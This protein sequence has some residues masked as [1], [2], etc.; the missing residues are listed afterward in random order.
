MM[1]QLMASMIDD[2]AQGQIKSLKRTS[3]ASEGHVVN[4]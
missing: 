4:L 3:K 2:W 1:L